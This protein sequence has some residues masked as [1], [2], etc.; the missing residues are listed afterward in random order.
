MKVDHVPSNSPM[1]CPG[2]RARLRVPGFAMQRGSACGEEGLQF[3]EFMMVYQF[4]ITEYPDDP[5]AS[6]KAAINPM[7]STMI[8]INILMHSRKKSKNNRQESP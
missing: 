1:A 4:L 3:C 6:H 5:D 7:S 8:Q 2:C